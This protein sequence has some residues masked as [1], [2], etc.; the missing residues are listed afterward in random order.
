MSLYFNNKGPQS[1]ICFP[2]FNNNIFFLFPDGHEKQQVDKAD[3][4]PDFIFLLTS[5]Q[6][7]LLTP[8]GQGTGNNVYLIKMALNVGMAPSM[9]L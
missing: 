4:C 5:F 3:F 6:S 9:L 2:F 7:H 1:P 8:V